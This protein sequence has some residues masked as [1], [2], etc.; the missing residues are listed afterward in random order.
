MALLARS[1]CVLTSTVVRQMG[2][3]S[4]DRLPFSVCLCLELSAPLPSVW[5]GWAGVRP[6]TGL[7]HLLT[8]PFT[9]LHR[10]VPEKIGD[11]DVTYSLEAYKASQMA[12]TQAPFLLELKCKKY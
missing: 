7:R 3:C 1:G 5:V 8:S 12:A 10:N 11:L 2:M 9:D 6:E 4:R